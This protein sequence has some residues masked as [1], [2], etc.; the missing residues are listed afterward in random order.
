MRRICCSVQGLAGGSPRRTLEIARHDHH[1]ST[2]VV[3]FANVSISSVFNSL[4]ELPPVANE[5]TDDAC[6]AR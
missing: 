6:H 2:I 3:T 5:I 4:I 1:P